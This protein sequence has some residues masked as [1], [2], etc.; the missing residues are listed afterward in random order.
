MTERSLLFT[1]VVD[2]TLMVERL[3]DARAA[4][5]WAEHDR[6]ARD[7]LALHRG[8]EINRS[9]GFFLLFDAASDAARFALAYH[10]VLVPLALN[11]R[12]GLHVGPVTLR[13]NLP[14][15]IARGAQRFEVEGIAIPL[16]AR[17]MSLA[18]GGQTLMSQSA[19]TA[20][21]DAVPAGA[22]VD[23]HGHYRLKGIADPVEVF[24]LG[25]PGRCAF[26]PPQDADKA[27]RVVHSGGLWRPVREVRHNL[28]HERDAFVGRSAE[29]RALALR[30]DAGSRL[31]TV[32]G[33]GGTGKTRLVSR[34]GLSWLG[35]WPGGVYFCDLSEALSREG[36]CFAVGQAL[37]VP[38]GKGDP[39]VQL[40]DAI[41]GRGRCLVI[42]DNFE[43]VQPHAP[44][45]VGRWLDRAA[46]AAFVVTSRERLH[47]PGEELFPVEPL[48]LQHEAIELFATRARAQRPD[49]VLGDANRGA[50]V[51]VV[52]LLDG[53]PLAIE[54]AAAR[55]RVLSPAQLVERM[56]DRFSLLAGARGASA[57]QATLKAAIDWSW[58]LLSPWEQ[59]A[60][61][62]CSVFDGGFT[63]EAAEAVLDLARWP[64]A[65][66]TIDVVQALVD[67]SLLRTWQPLAKGRYEIDEPYF[68]MYLS[69]REYATH[70]CV[71][72]GAQAQLAA[73]QRHGTYFGNFG[74]DDALEALTRHPGVGARRALALELNNLVAACRWALGRGQAEVAVGSYRAAWEVLDRHGPAALAV[75]LGEQVLALRGI[76]GALRA[77]ACS[78]LALALRRVGRVAQAQ[79]FVQEAL[80]LFHELGDRRR[81]GRMRCRLG[82]LFRDQGHMG[83]ALEQLEAALAMHRETGDRRAEGI[84]LDGLGFLYYDQGRIEQA[85]ACYVQGFAVHREVG[86]RP[87]EQSVLN[88]LAVM[89]AEQGRLQEARAQFEQSLAISRELD[90]R[91]AEGHL[92][93]NL[94]CLHQEQGRLQE[95]ASNYEMALVIHC[96]VGDRRFEG[97]VLGDLGRLQLELGAWARAQAYLE[98]SLAITRETGDR[99]IEG[100]ELR[101]LGE[102]FIAQ[103]RSDEARAA[104]ATAESVLRQVGDKFYLGFVLCG[105]AEI[106]RLAGDQYAARVCLDE[107]RALAAET[108]A[109]PESALGR[110]LAKLSEALA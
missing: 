66:P 76:A 59:A 81:E 48:E 9:D 109:G 42:L 1:D 97:Y 69:I 56:R 71:A 15:D 102:L 47:L 20:L 93:T 73:Q 46:N 12:V 107:A 37:G 64:Q 98:Q 39:G 55:T 40:G 74:T 3:G 72:S 103:G 45:T 106:E 68:G 27:Y 75:V 77:A 65:P 49:F 57:R 31:I 90:D 29:L 16:A 89:D 60:F 44:A 38:L 4:Q 34:Y 86:N 23:S 41:A 11:A 82:G 6:R 22:E 43:Q 104:L 94:G 54:L 63:L 33:P 53:L 8:R 58:E 26:V 80:E 21:G 2:S 52:R 51:E 110:K 5:L 25:V 36:V 88:L 84:T 7:L 18:R 70:K 28:L 32:L 96:E 87:G 83:E 14:D 35:D 108:R 100:S 30:L 85:R 61:A 79:V 13:E 19:R 67:K 105:R 10:E 95:A 91:V 101:S 92:L 17:V 99:R 24:E 50:V 62:Q 78:T